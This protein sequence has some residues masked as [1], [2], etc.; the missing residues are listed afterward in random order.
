MWKECEECGYTF[1]CERRVAVCP[2]CGLAARLLR[3]DDAYD[4]EDAFASWIECGME[5]D[6][7]PSAEWDGHLHP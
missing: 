5:T 2:S 6:A 4:E 1:R 7:A 3:C